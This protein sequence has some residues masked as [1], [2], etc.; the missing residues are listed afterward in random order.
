MTVREL[1]ENPKRLFWLLHLGGWAAWGLIAKY[2]YNKV[3]LEEAPPDYLAYVAVIT[4]I[5][6]VITLVLRQ[7]YH[8][9]WNRAIW[10][11]VLGFFAGQDVRAKKVAVLGGNQGNM[12]CVALYPVE[13]V[14]GYRKLAWV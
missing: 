10:L 5:G 7:I 4:A 9:V 13:R 6:I 2:A 11:R 3:V 1:I 12:V 14:L 8:F